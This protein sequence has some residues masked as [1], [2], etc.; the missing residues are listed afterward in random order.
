MV[1]HAPFRWERATRRALES[2]LEGELGGYDAVFAMENL[3][4]FAGQ[5]FSSAI[6][7]E[8]L[9][10]YRHV[11]FDTSHFA[12]S[13]IDLFAAWD[14]LA[15]RVVHL[16][17]S[18]NFGNGRDSHA[19]IGAGVLPLQEFLAHVGASGYAGA[20]TLEL[21]LR[22]HLEDRQ[23]LVAFLAGEREKVQRYLTG[24]VRQEPAGLPS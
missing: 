18:D 3:Y 22:A 10:P 5:Y 21:D 9:L 15:D 12:V 20:I 19:P 16:H 24:D 4:P 8:D 17:V 1:A 6:T 11:V 13:G 14:A 7:P 2:E 23:T